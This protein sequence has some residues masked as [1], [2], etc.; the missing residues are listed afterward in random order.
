MLVVLQ[1][2]GIAVVPLKVTVL[3]LA[4][5]DPKPLPVIVTAVPTDPVVGLKPVIVRDED[6]QQ[7]DNATVRAVVKSSRSNVRRGVGVKLFFRSEATPLEC[8]KCP[9]IDSLSSRCP[10]YECL[11]SIPADTYVFSRPAGAQR[12]RDHRFLRARSSSI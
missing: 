3:L 6:F 7:L 11:S 10:G 4:W 9:A 12:T 2:R 1:L 8:E 5:L